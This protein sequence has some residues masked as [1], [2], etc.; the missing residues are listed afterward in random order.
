M[1]EWVRVKDPATGHEI[2]ISAEQAQA[3]GASPINKPA[4]APSGDPL[5]PK[6]HRS[7]DEAAALG[8]KGA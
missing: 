4:T 8:R 7:I 6:Y 3:F 2:T 1:P 5:E